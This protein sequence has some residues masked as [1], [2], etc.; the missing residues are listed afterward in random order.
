M[1]GD[2]FDCISVFDQMLADFWGERK[3]KDCADRGHSVTAVTYSEGRT[4]LHFQGLAETRRQRESVRR[5]ATWDQ[6]QLN[7]SAAVLQRKCETQ[8]YP[9]WWRET[10]PPDCQSPDPCRPTARSPSYH[11]RR[12]LPVRP[13]QN[14]DGFTHQ[15]SGQQHVSRTTRLEAKHFFSICQPLYSFSVDEELRNSGGCL[16]IHPFLAVFTVNGGRDEGI[17]LAKVW[18]FNWVFQLMFNVLFF[19]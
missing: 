11:S 16:E 3:A 15:W 18:A 9:V 10:P 12:R 14:I 13:R 8:P 7:N 2:V 6:W 19:I 5:R 1:E 17:I 4:Y